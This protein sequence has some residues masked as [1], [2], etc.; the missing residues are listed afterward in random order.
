L[1]GNMLPSSSPLVEGEIISPEV[2]GIVPFPLAGRG[3]GGA[4][5]GLIEKE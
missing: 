2:G 1:I 4:V 3:W 5:H